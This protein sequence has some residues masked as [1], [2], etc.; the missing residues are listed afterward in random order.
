MRSEKVAGQARITVIDTGRG[1]T[2]DQ[3]EVVF[4]R[5]YR[6]DRSVAGGTGIGLTIARSLARLHGGDVTASSPGAGQGSTFALTL[7]VRPSG[8]FRSVTE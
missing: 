7:P 6:A 3:L 4:E 5:F 1:L 8:S 2:A